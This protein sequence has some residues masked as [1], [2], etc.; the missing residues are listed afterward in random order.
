MNDN[1]TELTQALYKYIDSNE[2][3]NEVEGENLEKKVE[4]LNSA[5]ADVRK[6]LE[7]LGQ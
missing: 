6:Q 7:E 2:N 4:Q 5:I 3:I 1:C